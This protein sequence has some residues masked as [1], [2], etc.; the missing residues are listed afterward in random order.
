MGHGFGQS[1]GP[2]EELGAS[3]QSAL[4]GAQLAGRASRS[5]VERR[6]LHHNLVPEAQVAW[7]AQ[8]DRRKKL[9][10][11]DQSRRAARNSFKPVQLISGL[12]DR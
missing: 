1:E 11:L 4:F 8:P 3:V 9:R 7:T 10:P 12:A 2:E 5:S 6:L